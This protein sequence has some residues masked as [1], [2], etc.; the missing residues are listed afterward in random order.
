MLW[1]LLSLDHTSQTSSGEEFEVYAI[2]SRQVSLD[3]LD[4]AEH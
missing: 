1:A 3:S 4:E 2:P